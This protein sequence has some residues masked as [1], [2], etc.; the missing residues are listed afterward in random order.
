MLLLLFTQ[1]PLGCRST[2]NTSGLVEIEAPLRDAIFPD[3]ADDAE[4]LLFVDG[5]KVL[6]NHVIWKPKR[7]FQSFGEGVLEGERVQMS[8]E[9]QCD[10]D[11]RWKTLH[12]KMPIHS[13]AIYRTGGNGADLVQ[14]DGTTNSVILE[15]GTLPF[16]GLKGAALKFSPL[17]CRTKR[18]VRSR[19]ASTV[20]FTKKSRERRYSFANSR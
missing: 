4:F 15:N 9:I 7:G 18:R 2:E 13:T 8:T 10:L 17:L 20:P 14:P 1:G 11:G 12:F 3:L 6:T 16:P 19:F 5:K